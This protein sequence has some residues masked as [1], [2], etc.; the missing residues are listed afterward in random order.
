MTRA[1]CRYTQLLEQ[2]NQTPFFCFAKLNYSLLSWK[3]LSVASQ[4]HSEYLVQ[5]VSADIYIQNRRTRQW[6]LGSIAESN[7]ATEEMVVTVRLRPTGN[8]GILKAG[9]RQCEQFTKKEGLKV[10]S[11]NRCSN[12]LHNKRNKLNIKRHTQTNK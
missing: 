12:K 2:N 1:V 8:A 11:E 3:V 6:P 10:T 4:S 5:G 9:V 7:K